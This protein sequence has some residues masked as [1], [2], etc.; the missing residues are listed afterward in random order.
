MD[1]K[2]LLWKHRVLLTILFF[3]L[4]VFVAILLLFGWIEFITLLW[5]FGGLLLLAFPLALFY[6]Y[7]ARVKGFRAKAVMTHQE[8]LTFMIDY[9]RHNYA[10]VSDLQPGDQRKFWDWNIYGGG[11]GENFVRVPFSILSFPDSQTGKPIVCICNRETG[12]VTWGWELEK[13]AILEFVNSMAETPEQFVEWKERVP[14][15]TPTGVVE[16]V[17][18]K[19][20]PISVLE[21]E[22]EETL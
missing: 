11:T 13:P 3:L 12:M 19:R 10:I 21:K 20:T 8:A 2:K 17:I 15:E 18:T 1:A 14:V 4:I 9:M 5:I 16:K 22:N 6:F 7:A